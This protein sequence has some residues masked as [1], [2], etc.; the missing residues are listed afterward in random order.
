MLM[1]ATK[2]CLPLQTTLL[3]SALK[4]AVVCGWGE[5]YVISPSAEACGRESRGE[6]RS[7]EAWQFRNMPASWEDSYDEMTKEAER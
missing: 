2:C 7:T 4:L 5:A 6:G 1:N 3:N